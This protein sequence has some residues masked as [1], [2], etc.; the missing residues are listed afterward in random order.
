[1]SC[2]KVPERNGVRNRGQLGT[3][4]SHPRVQVCRFH[5]M[6]QTA[7]ASERSEHGQNRTEGLRALLSAAVSDNEHSAV[8]ALAL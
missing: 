3:I 5:A 4:R 8:T 7:G 6:V 2:R 1:M